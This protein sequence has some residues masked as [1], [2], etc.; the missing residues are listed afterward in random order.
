[1]PAL[2]Y[3][4]PISLLY[5]GKPVLTFSFIGRHRVPRSTWKKYCWIFYYFQKL[6]QFCSLTLFWPLVAKLRFHLQERFALGG[7]VKD[8]TKTPKVR[9]GARIERKNSNND[10]YCLL[11]HI[12][13]D[14]WHIIFYPHPHWLIRFNSFLHILILIVQLWDSDA[15]HSCPAS[16]ASST[17]GGGSFKM[18][19]TKMTI[20]TKKRGQKLFFRT[21]I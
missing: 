19:I 6:R 8:A 5:R 9:I 18:I 3:T 4:S 1:M 16:R 21:V 14:W 2:S 12:L 11:I 7:T 13:T 17:A 15:T 10:L 20:M